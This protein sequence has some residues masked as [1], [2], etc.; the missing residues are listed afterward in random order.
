M[1]KQTK[2]FY[3]LGPFR[4]EPDERLLW[5]NGEIIRLKP[6]AFD[7]LVTLV[8]EDGHLTLARQGQSN[9]GPSKPGH[10]YD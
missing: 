9:R 7:L 2:H 1:S 3:E 5:R 8:A 6:K 10:D 4:L